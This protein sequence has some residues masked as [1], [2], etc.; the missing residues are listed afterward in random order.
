MEAVWTK[1]Q[2]YGGSAYTRLDLKMFMD[3]KDATQYPKLKGRGGQVKSLVEPLLRAWNDF[4]DQ[5]DAHDVRVRDL[6][7]A[8]L[9]ISDIIGQTSKAIFMPEEDCQGLMETIE[10][11]LALYTEL[12]VRADDEF[13]FL[14]P[15]VPKL[16][17]LWHMGFR[18]VWLHVRRVA[19]W[20]D[21]DYMKFVKKLAASCSYG[22]KRHMVPH[23][24]MTKYRQS[25]GLKEKGWVRG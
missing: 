20:L 1:I 14:F 21:E 25:L 8:L 3:V 16:H 2:V 12:G 11:F 7:E 22:M 18:A 5:A 9:K 15:G 13:D 23:K 6:L 17:W 19:C 4:M 10:V 24:L